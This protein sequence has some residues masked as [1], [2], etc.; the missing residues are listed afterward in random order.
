MCCGTS[1]LRNTSVSPHPRLTFYSPQT[2]ICDG[3]RITEG[4]C[5]PAG[6]LS[7]VARD[8]RTQTWS[9]RHPSQSYR[10]CAESHRLWVGLLPITRSAFLNCSGFP[11][12]ISREDGTVWKARRSGLRV[13]LLGDRRGNWFKRSARPSFHRRACRRHGPGRLVTLSQRRTSPSVRLTE[14]YPQARTAIMAPLPNT[15]SRARTLL[16]MS[17]TCGPSK[18]P[19]N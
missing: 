13:R 19:R 14:G 10:F 17:R 2:N 1:H 3:T 8:C 18:T 15:S 4:R 6:W 11:R 5:R 12:L 16:C 7:C 9:G